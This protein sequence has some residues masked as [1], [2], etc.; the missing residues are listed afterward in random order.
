M[1]AVTRDY[2]IEVFSKI[3]RS[4]WGLASGGLLTDE[5]KAACVQW[6][7]MVRFSSGDGTIHAYF[8]GDLP[9]ENE[10]FWINKQIAEFFY[11]TVIYLKS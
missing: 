3:D 1:I 6:T 9:S 8:H 7:L 2:D 5:I 10:R 4:R 11:A